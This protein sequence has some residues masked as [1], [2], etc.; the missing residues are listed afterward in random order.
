M[1][2]NHAAQVQ[3]CGHPREQCKGRNRR[4]TAAAGTHPGV[5]CTRR[6]AG[7]RT[8]HLPRSMPWTP[9]AGVGARRRVPGARARQAAAARGLAARHAMLSPHGVAPG[10]AKVRV[11]TAGA[12]RSPIRAA[13]LGGEQRS[14]GGHHAAMCRWRTQLLHG[15]GQRT[16]SHQIE[17]LE[18]QRC[19]GRAAAVPRAW[20]RGGRHWRVACGCV[21]VAFNAVAAPTVLYVLAKRAET[22]SRGGCPLSSGPELAQGRRQQGSQVCVA[23]YSRIAAAHCHHLRHDRSRGNSFSQHLGQR[24]YG[25]HPVTDCP[26]HAQSVRAVHAARARPTPRR[27]NDTTTAGYLLARGWQQGYDITR[28]SRTRDWQTGGIHRSQALRHELDERCR[29]KQRC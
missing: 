2:I 27:T 1:A 21:A 8:G 25:R 10:A 7:L 5:G 28:N 9:R 22:H 17:L 24:G 3:V 13:H 15:C 29:G 20:G 18:T 12:A 11:S 16:A 23:S 19:G 26:H 14:R 6:R 4:A